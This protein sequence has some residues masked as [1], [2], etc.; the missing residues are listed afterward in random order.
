MDLEHRTFTPFV[1]GTNGGMGKEG[2][3]FFRRLAEKFASKQ[4]EHYA[5][6]IAWIR[7]KLAL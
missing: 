6:V 7:T 1:L 3:M 5:T 2:Q 4:S